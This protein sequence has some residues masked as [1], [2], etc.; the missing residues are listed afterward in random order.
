MVVNLQSVPSSRE[1]NVICQHIAFPLC[2]HT[3]VIFPAK[4]NIQISHSREMALH[5]TN[6]TEVFR[7]LK[8]LAR[9]YR[10]PYHFTS[11]LTLRFGI[12][13][14]HPSVA[15]LLKNTAMRLHTCCDVLVK[16]PI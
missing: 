3:V 16:F 11:A 4:T 9:S 12:N 2:L 5:I 15:Q 8:L 1:C 13:P 14:C 7:I 10:Q 6:F